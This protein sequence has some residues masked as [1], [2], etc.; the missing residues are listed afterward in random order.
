MYI[1]F[2]LLLG[3]TSTMVYRKHICKARM[4]AYNIYIYVCV[5]VCVC[6]CLYGYVYT[7][8]QGNS[9][10]ILAYMYAMCMYLCVQRVVCRVYTVVYGVLSRVYIYQIVPS[11]YTYTY[12]CLDRYMLVVYCMYV[13]ISGHECVYVC[14][15]VCL[16]VCMHVKLKRLHHWSRDPISLASSLA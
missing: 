7:Y 2:H 1:H 16:C 15:C 3:I 10:Q 5:C 13:S 9:K 14:A 12:I 6:I 8:I 4:F 11:M